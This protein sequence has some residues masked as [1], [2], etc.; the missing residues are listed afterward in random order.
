MSKF[1]LFGKLIAKEGERDTLV[2]I[3][4]EA[5]RSME[6][7]DNCEIYLVNVSHDD[8]NSV[9]VYEIWSNESAHQASLSLES[10]QTLIQRAKPIIA[11]MERINT[12]VPR[13]GKGI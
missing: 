10:T 1:G 5:A 6:T 3:L 8:P 7:L 11:G 9:F 2:E 13:G 4:L 12:L